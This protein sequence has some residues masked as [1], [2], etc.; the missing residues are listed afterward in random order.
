M[1][2]R[3]AA[4][5][6]CELVNGC[7]YAAS[8]TTWEGW[9]CSAV[10]HTML[11]PTLTLDVAV[12]ASFVLV[13]VAWVAQLSGVLEQ[14]A[15]GAVSDGLD[16]VDGEVGVAVEAAAVRLDVALAVR[17]HDLARG[18]A[19]HQLAEGRP[20]RALA[21]DVVDL[22]GVGH[23]LGLV[24]ALAVLVHGHVLELR[25]VEAV[26]Q[27][28]QLV[29]ADGVLVLLHGV[30]QLR[31]VVDLALVEPLDEQLEAGGVVVGQLE[32]VLARLA[33]AV[34]LELG[35]EQLRVVA[36]QVAVEGPVALGRANVDVDHCAGE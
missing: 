15:A 16:Q 21:V 14:Q 20:G 34:A 3:D 7:Y 31:H 33:V 8:L 22:V 25:H 10:Q 9:R 17:V 6:S 24:E 36:E 30:D 1:V 23:E 32:R 4:L 2:A 5:E 11:A 35:L 28:V 12:G 18:D 13:V 26:A 27:Q 19:G 29:A